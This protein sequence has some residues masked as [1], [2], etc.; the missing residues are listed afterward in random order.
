MKKLFAFIIIMAIALSV[1]V[2]FAAGRIP[3][4]SAPDFTVSTTDGKTLSLSALLKEKALV[5]L[6]VFDARYSPSRIE[7]PW[8][9]D[10]YEDVGDSAEMLAVTLD[11]GA[12]LSAYRAELGLSMPVGYSEDLAAYLAAKGIQICSYPT[13][14]F[15][16]RDGEIVYTQSGYFPIGSQFRAIVDYCLSAP[17]GGSASSY[18]LLIRNQKQ[19]PV[20]GV[21]MYFYGDAGSR[22]CTSDSDGVITFAGKPALYHFQILSVPEGYSYDRN[23]EGI[24]DGGWVTVQV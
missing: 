16:G 10:V 24:C 23:Y 7:L 6:N 15:I 13:T 19:Q 14:L 11:P 18:N 5:V 17:E 9:D 3:A 1:V 22:T 21:V 20:S 12:A 4:P 8:M 2:A